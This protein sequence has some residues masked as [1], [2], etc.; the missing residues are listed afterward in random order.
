M[1]NL[2]EHLLKRP[3]LQMNLDKWKTYVQSPAKNYSMVC[4]KS[5]C[6]AMG[7]NNRIQDCDVHRPLA[8]YELSDLQVRK[9]F[10]L[11]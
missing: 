6:T 11:I 7:F 5:H 8:E 10:G 9:F 1:G 2:Q 3:A 4:V